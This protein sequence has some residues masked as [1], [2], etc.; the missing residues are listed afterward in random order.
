MPTM[1]KLTTAALTIA[2]SLILAPTVTSTTAEA[3]AKGSK[4]ILL[5]VSE[6]CE[7]CALHQRAFTKAVRE[8]GINLDVKINAFNAAEQASQVDQAIA[9][10][11]DALVVWPADATAIVPSLRKIKQA[12]IPLILT[13]S[14]PDPKFESLWV[15]FTGPDDVGNG[16]TAATVMKQGFQEKGFGSAGNVFVILG[17][18]GTPPQIQRLDGFTKELGKSASDIKI[19]GS[20]PGDWDQTKATDAAAALFTQYGDS[21]KGVYAEADNMLAGVI[22]AAQR[23]GKDPSKLVLVGSNCSIEG[24]KAIEAGQQY[25]TVLQSPVDD[26]LY[27]AK[28]VVDFLDGKTLEKNHLLP[29]PAITKANVAECNAAVGR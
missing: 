12:N 4:V 1:T 7:Y 2:G 28:A 14:K 27:A 9:Q 5:T 20:Q 17:V 29:H 19:V 8:A 6:S 16:Q 23:A 11:P 10:R 22:V 26:G 13:N 25:G 3:A 18:L 24:V 15:T 21:V